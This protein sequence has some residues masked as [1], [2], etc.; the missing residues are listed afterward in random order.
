MV[1]LREAGHNACRIRTAAVL[2]AGDQQEKQP[3]SEL[4]P[5]T[6][7]E[8]GYARRLQSVLKGYPTKTTL[9]FCTNAESTV[10]LPRAWAGDTDPAAAVALGR[11]VAH[12]FPLR[13][14]DEQVSFRSAGLATTAMN[15]EHLNTARD[16]VG[17]DRMC[18][19]RGA[20]RVGP[21]SLSGSRRYDRWPVTSL[22]DAAGWPAGW[23]VTWLAA[24]ESDTSRRVSPTTE[25]SCAIPDIEIWH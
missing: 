2:D 22:D 23:T 1:P 8:Q 13:V 10:R 21:D 7:Q 5:G 24:L 9:V 19:R 3:F 20:K 17:A 4:R 12:L 18:A 11:I 6:E 16:G 25:T 15:P 14:S